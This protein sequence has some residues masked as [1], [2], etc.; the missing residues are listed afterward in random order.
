VAQEALKDLVGP[1]QLR[2]GQ[3]HVDKLPAVIP[4]PD[5]RKQDLLLFR[6]LGEL[7]VLLR[8]HGELPQI[9]FPGLRSYSLLLSDDLSVDDFQFYVFQKSF[10]CFHL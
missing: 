9:A 8:R 5:G 10:S 3:D 7:M 1:I 6:Q 2:H 4:V